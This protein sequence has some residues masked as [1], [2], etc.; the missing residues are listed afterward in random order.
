MTALGTSFIVLG[1]AFLFRGLIFVLPKPFGRKPV[2]PSAQQETRLAVMA[3]PR[4]AA[5]YSRVGQGS[6]LVPTAN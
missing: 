5:C 1:V 6:R 4:S 3:R 2:Q